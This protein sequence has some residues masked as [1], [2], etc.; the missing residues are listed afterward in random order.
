[1]VYLRHHETPGTTVLRRV[2][3]VNADSN[4]QSKLHLCSACWAT[5]CAGY[6]IN[7][8]EHRQAQRDAYAADMHRL[9]LEIDAL[10]RT[11]A[12]LRQQ[13][14][15]GSSSAPPV[16][17]SHSSKFVRVYDV[18]DSALL[19]TQVSLSKAA[20]GK[21]GSSDYRKNKLMATAPLSE[22]F[23]VA[24]HKVTT[25]VEEGDQDKSMH[26]SAARP[27]IGCLFVPCLT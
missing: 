7:I 19:E 21:P 10:K 18:P 23:G 15:Q 20:Y 5:P 16:A 27:W 9:R 8:K 2:S 17:T 1:M 11:N 4:N 24:R 13:Q 26:V 3:G 12:F 14:S 22:K 25:D 6:L